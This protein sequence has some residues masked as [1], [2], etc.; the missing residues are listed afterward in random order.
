MIV[1]AENNARNGT[2]VGICLILLI[3]VFIMDSLIPLGV[4]GGVPYILVVLVALWSTNRRLPL[5]MAIAG[6]ILTIVGYYSSPAGGE[7]WKVLFNRALA[8]FAIWTTAVLSLQRNK[9]HWEKEKALSEVKV[10]Q[11]LLPICSSCKKVRDDKGSWKQV[12][13]YI[14][15]H[16]EALFSHGVCPDCVEKLYADLDKHQQEKKSRSEPEGE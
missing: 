4:A 14:S 8:L 5:Y 13:S 16:S 6:S 10:L 3:V 15:A 1:V 12:E 7:M 11:G 9:I 2:V